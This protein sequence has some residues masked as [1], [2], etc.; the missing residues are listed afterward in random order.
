MLI[1][2]C[3]LIKHCFIKIKKFNNNNKNNNNMIKNNN[4][5]ILKNKI[6]I[7]LKM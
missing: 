5:K 6:V 3:N 7:Q 4:N 2:A 1:K